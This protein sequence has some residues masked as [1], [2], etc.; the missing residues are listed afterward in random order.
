MM[1]VSAGS[2]APDTVKK[3]FTVAREGQMSKPE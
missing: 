3:S 1:T 2:P